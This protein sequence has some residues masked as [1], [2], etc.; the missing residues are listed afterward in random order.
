MIRAL[1]AVLALAVCG[2][3]R[4]A[5]VCADADGCGADA[6]DTGSGSGPDADADADGDLGW[7]TGVEAEACLD[8]GNLYDPTTSLCWQDPPPDREMGW[9]EAIA[10][11]DGLDLGGFDDWRLP[12]ISELRSLIRKCPATMAGGTCGV[13]DGCSGE[14]CRDASCAGCTSGTTPEAPCYWAWVL[15]GPCDY[16]WSSSSYADV[17]TRAWLVSFDRAVVLASSDTFT[18]YARCVR[19]GP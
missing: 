3:W 12:G 2:C 10:H 15:H 13:T 14:D 4:S 18:H 7:D 5:Q 8:G 19:G 1:P 9:S 16:Y 6:G 11:C 17:W